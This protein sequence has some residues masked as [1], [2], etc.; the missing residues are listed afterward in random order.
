MWAFSGYLNEKLDIEG[1]YIIYLAAFN[2]Y[3]LFTL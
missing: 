3:S 1:D 2:R